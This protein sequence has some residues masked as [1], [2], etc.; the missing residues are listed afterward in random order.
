[1]ISKV[2]VTILKFKVVDDPHK[3]FIHI[4]KVGRMFGHMVPLSSFR[5]NLLIK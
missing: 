3:G 2:G 5:N 4:R 1:M